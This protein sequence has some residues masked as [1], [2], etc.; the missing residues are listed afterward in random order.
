MG[1]RHLEE[2]P[3]GHSDDVAARNLGNK[4][5]GNSP[6]WGFDQDVLPVSPGYLDWRFAKH[7]LD[8]ADLANLRGILDQRAERAGQD[9]AE[10]VEQACHQVAAAA[11]TAPFNRTTPEDDGFAA[12]SM[13]TPIRI[14]PAAAAFVHILLVGFT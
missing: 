9:A 7:R 8:V 4:V 5:S 10:A 13:A 11:G 1:G 2:S 6:C 12:A 3:V 14:A